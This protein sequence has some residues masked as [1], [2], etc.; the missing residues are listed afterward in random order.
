MY[1]LVVPLIVFSFSAST[2][3]GCVTGSNNQDDL[4]N[5]ANSVWSVKSLT[6]LKLSIRIQDSHDFVMLNT[7]RNFYASDKTQEEAH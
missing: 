2:D 6:F 3:F 5:V 4:G 7:R 1:W